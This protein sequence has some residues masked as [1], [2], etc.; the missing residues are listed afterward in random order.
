MYNNSANV[1]RPLH[2]NQS[3][4]DEAWYAV[5]FYVLS[6]C[7]A[8]AKTN[9]SSTVAAIFTLLAKIMLWL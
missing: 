3:Y 6:E 5:E 9:S 4:K 8:E 2:K 1:D 7:L